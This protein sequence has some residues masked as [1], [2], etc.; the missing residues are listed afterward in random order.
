ML[1]LLIDSQP[2][3]L[4]EGFTFEIHRENPLFFRSGDYTYDI[5][6]SLH[7]PDNRRL[8]DHV[9]R[10]QHIASIPH[11]SALLIEDDKVLMKGTEA[12]LEKIGDTV[13]IQILAGNAELNYLTGDETRIR[14]LN[15]GTVPIPTP[16]TAEDAAY[17]LYPETRHVF[18]PTIKAYDFKSDHASTII[19]E[20]DFTHIANGQYVDELI[21]RDDTELHPMPFFMYILEKFIQ[22]LGYTLTFNPYRDSPKW[23]RLL[24]IHGYVTLEYAK[25]LPDWTTAKFVQ[26]VEKFLNCIILID[27]LTKECQ[28]IPIPDY[29]QNKPVAYIQDND[30]LDD[31]DIAFKADDDNFFISYENLSYNLPSG[32]YWKYARL[33]ENVKDICGYPIPLPPELLEDRIEPNTFDYDA[34]TIYYD[35][36]VN[37]DFYYVV[38]KLVNSTGWYVFQEVDQYKDFVRNDTLEPVQF[39]IVPCEIH[40]A[41]VTI[42]TNYTQALLPYPVFYE[43]TTSVG[44]HEAVINGVSDKASSIMQVAFYAGVLPCYSTHGEPNPMSQELP[45]KAPQCFCNSVSMDDSLAPFSI[46]ATYIPEVQNMNLKFQ[47][48][49]GRVAQDFTSPYSIDTTHKRTIRFLSDKYIDPVSIFQIQNKRYACRELKY[50]FKNGQRTNIVEGIFYPIE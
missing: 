8:Y 9:D 25:M 7:D 22:L 32:D 24:I 35:P 37:R 43:R 19:N 14:S 45:T 44:L 31:F 50:T 42:L 23:A 41:A 46:P 26:E 6:L 48:I 20:I 39:D 10:I 21:Y 17:K 38:R 5:E 18:P 2:V 15:F 29:Y 28:I 49:H 40:S 11:R 27:P 36:S 1:T 16:A 12:V 33:N 3:T 34:F 4:P 13:K 30:I 47:T